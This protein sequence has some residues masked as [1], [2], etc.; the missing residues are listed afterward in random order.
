MGCF[1]VRYNSR[2]VI[3]KHKLFIR[4]ATGDRDRPKSIL[5]T[6]ESSIGSV[7]PMIRVIHH[8]ASV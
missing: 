4:L 2:V 8:L 6:Q 5:R 7:A 3:Y 1:Q